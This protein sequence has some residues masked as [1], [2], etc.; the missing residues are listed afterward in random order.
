MAGKVRAGML[1]VPSRC[2]VRLPH[3]TAHDVAAIDAAVRDAL[4]ELG[5]VKEDAAT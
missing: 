2:A 3:L 5:S 4:T 1:S